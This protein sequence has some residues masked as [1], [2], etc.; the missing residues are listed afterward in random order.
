MKKNS[1]FTLLEVLIAVGILGIG[2]L[3]VMQ[4]FPSAL[5]QSR[6]A[7]EKSVATGLASSQAAQL[8]TMD[9]SP[10]SM[11]QWLIANAARTLD[12]A[13]SSYAMY[14][15][16]QSTAERMPGGTNTY[17]V[18]FRVNMPNDRTETF[19]TYVTKP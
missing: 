19:V 9:L 17:R 4:L 10:G 12:S 13:Q 14:E 8:R 1:G 6:M 18:T 15:G 16:W 11:R 3:A 7:A 5:K 2:I